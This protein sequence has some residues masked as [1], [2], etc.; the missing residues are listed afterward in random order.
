MI[1]LKYISI[2]CAGAILISSC[3]KVTQDYNVDPNNPQDAT[4]ELLMNGAMVGTI[5]INEGNMARYSGIFTKTFTGADRQYVGISTYN[6]AAGDFDDVWG[7]LY[8]GVISNAK[9]AEDKAIVIGNLKLAGICEIIQANGY[10]MATSLWGDVPFSE[11]VQPDK[12]TT[13]KFD[14]Q[15][16]IYAGLQS[17]LDKAIANL[18]S[19]KPLGDVGTAKDFYFGGNS[20]KWIA[21][22]HSLKARYYLH[23]K[24]YA[25]ASAES[26]L[27]ISSSANDWLAPHGTTSGS[28]NN[29]YWDFSNNQRGGYMDASDSYAYALLLGDRNNTKTNDSIRWAYFFQDAANSDSGVDD[30]NFY[31]TFFGESSSFPLMTYIE[32]KLIEIES[33]AKLG[34][35]QTSIDALN[36]LRNFYVTSEY[37]GA[38]AKYDSLLVADFNPGG[39]YN[40]GTLTANAAL[41]KEIASERYVALIGQIEQFNDVRRNKNLVGIVPRQGKPKIPQRMLLP[42]AEINSNPNTPRGIDQFTDMPVWTSAY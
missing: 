5:L 9:Q 10:G 41:L 16:S 8:T 17:L 22:A 4:P 20:A 27:G 34:N 1:K 29:V 28:D 6:L 25:Q 37:Y 26:K 2:F 13:P 7:N 3:K 15:A 35:T 31:G 30:L 36:G 23:T 19:S 24:N 21:A 38:G 12:F 14:P 11:A 18:G 39:L 40:S 42:Q 33:E 32:T